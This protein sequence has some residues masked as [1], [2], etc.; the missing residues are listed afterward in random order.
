MMNKQITDA[1]AG[2]GYTQ[3]DNYNLPDLALPTEKEQHVGI[4][5]QRRKR[6]L[7]E[8]HCIL[9]YNLHLVL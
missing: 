7:K 6:Y 1:R 9:Y 2:I 8:Y 5:A 4:W 3:Q